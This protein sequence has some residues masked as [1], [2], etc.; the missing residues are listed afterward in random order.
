MGSHKTWSVSLGDWGG[1]PVR[2]H[3]F[4]LLFAAFTVYLGWRAEGS[5]MERGLWIAAG[6]LGILLV[7]VLLH[8]LGHFMAASRLGGS[9]S[10]L[11]VGP[12][13]GLSPMRPPLDPVAE[14]GVHLAGPAVN[15]LICL[16]TGSA[17]VAL[18]ISPRPLSLLNVLAPPDLV[19]NGP[20]WAVGC[21][22]TFWINW[23][24]VLINLLPAFPFDG[25]RAL[26]AGVLS[27]WPNRG[28]RQASLAVATV[29][30]LTAFALLVAAV[31]L[32]G[33][34]SADQA[35][36]PAWTA[37]L[38]LAIFLYFSA[39]QEAEQEERPAETSD[40]FGYDFSQGYTSL[41]RSHP[42]VEESVSP[43][44]KWLTQRKE[45]RQQRQRALE[46][47]EELRVD[48]ILSRLHAHGIESLSPD[49][50]ALLDRVSARYRRQR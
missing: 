40:A 6:S 30:K 8:E 19:D 37:L 7:S 44:Q 24:L 47:E 11:I 35:L 22:L 48:D 20:P 5:E 23:L 21:K 36:V 1:L 26:R 18:D 14:V 49:D 9:M 25:G 34:E 42:A 3:A 2:L 29:A 31:I 27:I 45:A 17:A 15:L 39:K 46:A 28:V 4:F 50:R 16:L 32:A 33:R 43:V 12:L 13:G 41:E 10:E 38:M